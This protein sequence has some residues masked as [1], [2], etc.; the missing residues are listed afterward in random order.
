MCMRRRVAPEYAADTSV[1]ILD[2]GCNA[3][4]K[5]IGSL[6]MFVDH[7]WNWTMVKL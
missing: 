1:L 7:V 6:T 5:E 3:F 4:E 2:W